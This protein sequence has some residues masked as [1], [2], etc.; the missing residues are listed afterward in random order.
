[1]FVEPLIRIGIVGV[2]GHILERTLERK[3]YPGLVGMVK[4]ATYV[5]CG[6][7]TCVYLNQ[8]TV[9]MT[10]LFGVPMPW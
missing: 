3:G 6:L 8:F 7:I 10:G 1:M 4:I 5:I 2:A 9:V